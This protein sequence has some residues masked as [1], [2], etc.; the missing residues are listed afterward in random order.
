MFIR[1]Q[2]SNTIELQRHLQYIA[3]QFRKKPTVAE[4]KL[5]QYL[6][7]RKLNG[8]KFNRQY[9]IYQYIADFY[10]HEY[11]LIIEVDGDIHKLQQQRDESRDLM[12]KKYGYTV[13]RFNN[14]QVI[15]NIDYV[16][17]QIKSTPPSP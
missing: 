11:K 13:L 10:C 14:E 16:L 3:K 5:W 9:P 17:K 8:L 4:Q 1:P 6:R 12:L 15:N 2:Q 7:N